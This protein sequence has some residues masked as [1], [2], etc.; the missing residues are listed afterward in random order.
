M[1]AEQLRAS[2]LLMAIEGKLVPQLNCEPPVEELFD[3]PEDIPFAIPEKWKWFYLNDVIQLV[4][5]RDLDKNLISERPAEVPYITGAS[6]IQNG[7]VIVNR[8]TNSPAVISKIG[9]VLLTCKGTVGKVAVNTIGNLHI[10]RQIM[11]IRVGE[12]IDVEYMKYFL[13]LQSKSFAQSAKGLIPGIDRKTVLESVIPIPPVEEQHRIVAKL[14]QLLPLVEEYGKAQDRL[15]ELNSE[16]GVKLRASVL[17]EAIQ[18]KLV[19]QLDCEPIVESFSDE[20]EDVP[21]A[22]PAKWKWVKLQR[23]FT[24][25]TSGKNTTCEKRSAIG[26]EWGVIK[27]TAIQKN[28]FNEI[29]NK[30]LPTSFQFPKVCKISKGDF[31]MTKAGPINRVGICC[32]VQDISKNLILSGHTVRLDL[33]SELV[34]PQY[35]VHV[36]HS[37]IIR[38]SFLDFMTGMADSQVNLKHG[39][40]GNLLIPLPPLEEQRRIVDK[41]EEI[42]THLNHWNA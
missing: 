10:A 28:F 12:L 6:Q 39:S 8:W 16:V 22:I 13:I 14:E 29:E 15:S 1:N 41:L 42:L 34:D 31:L 5:G 20:P 33:V 21:F 32:V 25:I 19:P 36:I 35:L 4:S 2:L 27:T 7:E 24:N 3:D 17:N 26:D 9:D 11:A 37:P 40:L 23:L 30:V 38:S 18:G